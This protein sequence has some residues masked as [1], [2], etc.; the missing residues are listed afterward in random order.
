MGFDL[1]DVA[2][3]ATDPE[4]VN[5]A[6]DSLPEGV[7]ALVWVGNLDNAPPGSAC[8]A[9]AFSWGRFTAQVDAL[10]SNP[11]VYGYYL[12][13]E[14]HPG[15]CP[16]AAADIKARADYIHATAPGQT[17][18]IVVQDGSAGCG[19]DLG[20]EYR[21]LQPARTDVD[22]IG[23]DPYPCHYDR[24]GNPAPCDEALIS[25]RVEAALANGVPARSIVPLFQVFGQHGRKDG[26]TGYY[27]MPSADELSAILRSWSTLV[28]DP[29]FDYFYT[30]G[31]QCSSASCPAPQAI[32]N[33]PSIWQVV[34]AHNAR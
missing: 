14:P 13:D 19:A 7:R 33:S 27:R 5:V 12:A 23:L 29:A 21:A 4:R 20:C 22:L 30:F 18:F 26:A 28:P 17:A 16:G 2:G 25:G 32:V 9:P 8:P 3:D 31:V 6:V 10:E 11:R 34:R 24:D 1:F 15:A